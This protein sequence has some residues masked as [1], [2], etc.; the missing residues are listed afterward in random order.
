VLAYVCVRAL[1][2]EISDACIVLLYKV[3]KLFFS[4]HRY[5]GRTITQAVRR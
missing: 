2:K 5:R 4:G 1:V 3:S